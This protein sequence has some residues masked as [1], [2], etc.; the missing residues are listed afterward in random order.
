MERSQKSLN[1]N[2]NWI[3][4]R[5][6]STSPTYSPVNFTRELVWQIIFLHSSNTLVKML[7]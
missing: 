2:L 1:L 5:I 3:K 6:T 7:V 4:C